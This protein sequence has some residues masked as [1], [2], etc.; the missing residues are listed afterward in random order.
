[1]STIRTTTVNLPETCG[2]PAE[3]YTLTEWNDGYHFTVAG[4]D[5]TVQRRTENL[6]RPMWYLVMRNVPEAM[7]PRPDGTVRLYCD[8]RRDAVRTAAH[9][10]RLSLEGITR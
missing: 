2:Q 9:L 8:T 4:I 7:H 3:S 1:M 10:H 6:N 5:C